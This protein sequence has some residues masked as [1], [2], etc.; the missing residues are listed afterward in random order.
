MFTT[1][2]V[3]TDGSTS[4]SYAVDKAVE[5]AAL[6]GAEL[7]VV[8]ALERLLGEDVAHMSATLP[9]EFR[10]GFD[11]H[12]ARHETLAEAVAAA[13]LAGVTAHGHDFREHPADAILDIADEVDAD[14]IV[15]GSRGLGVTKRFFLGS[16][17]TRLAHHAHRSVL[18]THENELP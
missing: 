13:R 16:V 1:I 9:S 4:G 15:V 7:H 3:G 5:L 8:V 10:D 6:S 11:P 2:V 14:L 12:A 17:S 18:I